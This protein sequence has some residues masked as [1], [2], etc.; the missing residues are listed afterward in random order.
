MSKHTVIF[1]KT[2]TPPFNWFDN[3][4]NDVYR[5]ILELE[6]WSISLTVQHKNKKD[7]AWHFSNLGFSIYITKNFRF[8]SNHIYFNGSHCVFS[9][10]WVHFYRTPLSRWCEKCIPSK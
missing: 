1:K 5:W 7:R 2:T 8:G 10:G 4:I 9:L 6:K 3:E